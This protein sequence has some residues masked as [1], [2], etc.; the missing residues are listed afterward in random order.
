[1]LFCRRTCTTLR[2]DGHRR[3]AT[4]VGS[5]VF[6]RAIGIHRH[7]HRMTAA[8]PR[9]DAT[10]VPAGSAATRVGVPLRI[11]REDAIAWDDRCDVLVAGFGAAGASAAIEAARAGARVVAADRFGGGGASAKSGGVVYAGGGTRFQKAAGYEDSPDAMYEYLSK[12]VGDAVSPATLRTFC[13]HSVALL[14]WL[15]RDRGEVHSSLSPPA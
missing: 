5:R 6:W 2:S 1:D 11:E 15:E 8:A 9:V 13:E 12:E 3:Q 7:L 10:A 14:E 4:A